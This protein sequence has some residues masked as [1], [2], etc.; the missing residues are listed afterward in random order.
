MSLLNKRN[1]RFALL[2]IPFP[3]TNRH[4][5]KV[6]QLQ[7]HKII[8]Q[9]CF[10]A[11][12]SLGVARKRR[13]VTF[14]FP[15]WILEVT[16]VTMQL[17]HKGDKIRASFNP[18]HRWEDYQAITKIWGF[19]QTTPEELKNG[20][21]TLAMDLIFSVDTTLEKLNATITGYFLICAW[22]K[23]FQRNCIWLSL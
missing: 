1:V 3:I 13:A 14:V 8:T 7:S 10:S 5:Q 6:F 4:T 2:I 19:V 15:K 9:A 11:E 12:P 22:V 20:G 21:F 18:I 17:T 23:L 16:T